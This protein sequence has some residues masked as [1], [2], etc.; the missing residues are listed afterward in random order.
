MTIM[1]VGLCGC[2]KWLNVKPYDKISEDELLKTEAGFEK[3]L[4]GIYIELNREELYGS[5]L[6]VEMVE[7]MGGAYEI[8]DESNIW[9]NY[10]DLRDYKYESE[11]WRTRFTATW[12]KAYSLI[13]NCNKLLEKIDGKEELFS[14]N[15]YDMF[16]GES[17]ALRAMLHFDM[18]RLFGPVYKLHPEAKSIPYYTH[19]TTVPEPQ[20]SAEDI[21]NK[22]INDLEQALVFLEKDPIKTEGTLMTSDPAGNSNYWR[23]RQLRLNYYAVEALLARAHLWAGNNKEAYKRAWDVIVAADKGIFPFVKSE[24]VIGS[25]KDPDRIFSSEVIFALTHSQRV[26]LFKNYFDPKRTTFTFKMEN[27]LLTKTIFGGNVVTGGYQDDYRNRVQWSSSG[28]NRYFVQYDD[29]IANGKIQNTMI[30]MIR[31][32]ELFLICAETK[33]DN[34]N[35]GAGLINML[36]R[37]RG[38]KSKYTELDQEHLILEYIRELYGEG[39]LFYLYKRLYTN[40]IRSNDPT[41]NQLASPNVFV[42]P[43]PED[44]KGVSQN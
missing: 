24:D 40:I 28:S 41:K 29:M 22:V 20:L 35:D 19:S 18:L 34:L 1:V 26:K 38:I 10:T 9:G 8:G 14:G 32:G 12:N 39:Q 2:S 23:F 11:Y 33:T 25:V 44:E 37:N 30:P 15:A 21:L 31:L 36:R 27:E 6:S 3:F 7:I 13:L 4:N 42:V 17:L 5:S 43:L 16:R